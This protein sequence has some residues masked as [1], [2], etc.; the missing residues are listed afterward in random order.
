MENKKA[1]GILHIQTETNMK[2]NSRI[3]WQM[4]MASTS[5]Q[6]QAKDTKATGFKTTSTEMEKKNILINQA[7]MGSFPKERRTD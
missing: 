2:G 4:V 1:M 6:R 3:I 7:T 5:I